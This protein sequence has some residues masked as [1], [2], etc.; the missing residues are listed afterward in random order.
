MIDA[1]YG[2]VVATYEGILLAISGSN[3]WV[4]SDNDNIWSIALQ[5]GAVIETLGLPQDV[6][7]VDPSSYDDEPLDIEIAAMISSPHSL[8][9]TNGTVLLE[10]AV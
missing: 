10:Y 5:D 2:S 6:R 1:N 3:A 4:H 7:L 8:L 9:I